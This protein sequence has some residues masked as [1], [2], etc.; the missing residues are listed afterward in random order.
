MSIF[1]CEWSKKAV[2]IADEFDCIEDVDAMTG[3]DELPN[4]IV[5]C[6]ECWMFYKGESMVCDGCGEE[7]VGIDE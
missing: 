3:C 6:V 1:V 2:H 4:D 7:C 5:Y